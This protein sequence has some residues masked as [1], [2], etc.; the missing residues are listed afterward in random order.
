MRSQ[1]TYQAIKEMATKKP[2]Y[3]LTSELTWQAGL[4]NERAI[5]VIGLQNFADSQ[6][7]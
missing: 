6:R 7:H 4:L 1:Q 3:G 5:K 2:L